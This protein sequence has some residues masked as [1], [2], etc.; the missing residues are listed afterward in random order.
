M[1]G[2]SKVSD[3]ASR[4]SRVP[5]RLAVYWDTRG[6]LERLHSYPKTPVSRASLNRLGILRYQ[7]S[8]WRHSR[9]SQEANGLSGHASLGRIFAYTEDNLVSQETIS[10]LERPK[11]CG[12]D[13]ACV[14]CIVYSP[15]PSTRGSGRRFVC[16]FFSIAPCSLHPGPCMP[17]TTGTQTTLKQGPFERQG[18]GRLSLRFMCL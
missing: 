15:A 10:Y 2:S 1:P 6:S 14:Y 16:T 9:V 3:S 13:D 18:P 11:R 17:Q 4:E 7:F 8:I 12:D 5:R